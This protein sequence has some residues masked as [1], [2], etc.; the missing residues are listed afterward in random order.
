MDLCLVCPSSCLEQV[1][2]R[3]LNLADDTVDHPAQLKAIS[4]EAITG[5]V[6][7]YHTESQ[8]GTVGPLGEEG[9]GSSEG[10]IVAPPP[11]RRT[12]SSS[13]IDDPSFAVAA[14]GVAPGGPRLGLGGGGEEVGPARQA[15]DAGIPPGQ[16]GHGGYPAAEAVELVDAERPRL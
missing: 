11:G 15:V 6:V 5:V 1:M 4:I 13:S 14:S 2:R 7:H 16:I 3:P 12:S 10:A 8:P 9:R